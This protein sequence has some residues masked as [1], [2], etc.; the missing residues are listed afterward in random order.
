KGLTVRTYGMGR[1]RGVDDVRSL[2]Y[3]QVRAEPGQLRPRDTE[4][5]ARFIE[6]F[7]RMD[8]DGT[9]PNFM[10]VSLGENHTNGTTPGSYTPK[11]MVASND[12]AVGRIVETISTSKLWPEFAIFIIEDDAQNGPDHVDSHRTAGLVISPYVKRKFV[13][14][15]MYST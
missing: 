3:E 6:E 12:L 13:D 10:F 1:R 4:R 11:A 5:A 8:R 9:V 15:T 7:E 14:S 2:P